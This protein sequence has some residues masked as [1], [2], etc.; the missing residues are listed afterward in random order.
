MSCIVEQ[1]C[2]KIHT[3]RETVKEKVY[4]ECLNYLIEMTKALYKEFQESLG[5]DNVVLN[6]IDVGQGELNLGKDGIKLKKDEVISVEEYVE[7]VVK[8]RHYVTESGYI[9]VPNDDR[10]QK[11]QILITQIRFYEGSRQKTLTGKYLPK[12][13]GVIKKY[14]PRLTEEQMKIVAS[15]LEKVLERTDET[16]VPPH[17]DTEMKR[18]SAQGYL[19]RLDET[20]RKTVSDVLGV[21]KKELEI[22]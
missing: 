7:R 16:V 5:S 13:T 18:T 12:D 20:Q 3:E 9:E 1:G 19:D 11:L 15:L 17:E 10:F 22:A 4:S 8:N 2:R 14:N 21:V 6:E